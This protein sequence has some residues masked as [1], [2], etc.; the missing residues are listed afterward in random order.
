MALSAKEEP[1]AS[2]AAGDRSE[3]CPCTELVSVTERCALAA[4]RY[5][6][7][8]D[9]READE[10]AS[11][12]MVDALAKLPISGEVVIGR[13]DEAHLLTVGAKVGSGGRQ[14]ELAVDPVEGGPVLARG[15][16]GAL[17][18]L[19]AADPGGLTPLP[20]MYMKKMAVGPV[21]AA[22]STCACRCATT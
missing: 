10:A 6:G 16:A 19:A 5:L 4:G 14:M 7:R 12:A 9:A 2:G 3:N 22:A 18:I 15:Q 20:R 8:G 11:R 17:S 1:A 13:Q 21:A